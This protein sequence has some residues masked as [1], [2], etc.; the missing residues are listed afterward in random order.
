MKVITVS[1]P[2]CG[3][4]IEGKITR[5]LMTCAYCGTRFALEGEELEA[6]VGGTEAEDEEYVSDEDLESVEDFARE[7]C[8]EFREAVG[9]SS[10][11]ETHKIRAGLSILDDAEVFLIHDDTIFE[12]GKNG[13]AITDDGFYCRDLG[14]G[15][16]HFLY[17]GDLAAAGK[18]YVEGQYVMVDSVQIAYFS[19]SDEV[20]EELCRLYRKLRKHDRNFEWE[21]MDED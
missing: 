18:P 20:R 14:E 10:F 11:R 2:S 4:Q 12:S 1:C 16:A 8:Q 21:D 3:A 13:F 6:L 7:A 5:G 19:G 17:W 9:G 15:E